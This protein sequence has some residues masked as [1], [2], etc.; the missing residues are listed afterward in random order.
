[1]DIWVKVNRVESKNESLYFQLAF[2]KLP[3][4]YIGEIIAVLTNGANI[5]NYPPIKKKKKK[6]GKHSRP[7]FD[8]IHKN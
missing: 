7:L 1:M 5:I 6:T 3:R 8:N 4:K 2:T